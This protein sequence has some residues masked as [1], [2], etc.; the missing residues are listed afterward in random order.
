[1]EYSMKVSVCQWCVSVCT[2]TSSRFACV[3]MFGLLL[4]NYRPSV[5]ACK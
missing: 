1:M 4:F 3:P 2:L 5:K